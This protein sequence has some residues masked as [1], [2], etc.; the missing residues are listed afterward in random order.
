MP[1]RWNKSLYFEFGGELALGHSNLKGPLF[2]FPF[3]YMPDFR[4]CT[5]G[6]LDSLSHRLIRKSHV[7]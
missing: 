7:N 2:K 4:P 6:T 5:A 3:S 1:V